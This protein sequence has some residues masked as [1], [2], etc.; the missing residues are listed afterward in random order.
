M[1]LVN[2]LMMTR[3]TELTKVESRHLA[4]AAEEEAL[5][6]AWISVD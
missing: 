5:T 4:N 6:G 1:S 3:L 2:H